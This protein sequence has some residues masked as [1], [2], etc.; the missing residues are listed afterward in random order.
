MLAPHTADAP[1]K[2][3]TVVASVLRDVAKRE[4]VVSFQD[5]KARSRA[6]APTRDAKAALLRHGCGVV[7]EIKRNSPVFGPTA[8]TY[9]SIEEVAHAIEQGGAHLIACQT[10]RLRFDGSL[11]DMAAAREAVELPMVCRDVIVDPYQIHEARCYG[12]DVLP[13][14]VEILE[15]ARLAALLARAESLGMVVMAEVR[16]PEEAD[17]ALQAG[18]SVIAVNSWSFETNSLN[19]DAFAEIAPGLPSEVIKISLGGVA[20]AKDLMAAAACGADAV[21]AAEA[22]MN[23]GDILAATRK[24][25]AAG[26]HP[27]CPSRR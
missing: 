12:A 13:L 7:A 10:E 16:T 11:A 15:Q 2:V 20:T 24:L 23:G 5:I 3:N 27:A 17:R 1:D 14:Q 6:M 22:I 26:Q 8:A 25:A 18:A 21:L 9:Q 4:S 19:R